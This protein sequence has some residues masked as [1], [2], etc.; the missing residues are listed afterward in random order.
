MGERDD[1]GI[2]KQVYAAFGAGDPT[3]GHDPGHEAPAAL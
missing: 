3:A 1:V 2:V